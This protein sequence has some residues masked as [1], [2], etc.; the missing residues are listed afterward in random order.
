MSDEMEFNFTKEVQGDRTIIKL[1]G[2]INERTE[3]DE[4]FETL[5][6]DKLS[7]NLKGITRINSCGVRSWVNATKPLADRFQIEYVECSRAIVDQLNM[8]VNFLSS[9]KIVSL[10][11]PYYCE[12]CDREYE[13]LII[14]DEHFADEE[15]REE[16]EAPDAE[17]PK[18]G[19]PM[20]FNEDEEKYFSFLSE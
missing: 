3:L 7:I 12:N 14:I 10:Y 19:K 17:C 13:T 18:C 9:G 20:E 8:I 16:P 5:E 11:A 2:V 15:D 6:G 4:L 1:S